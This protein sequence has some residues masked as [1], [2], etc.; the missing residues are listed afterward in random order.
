MNAGLS[1][2]WLLVGTGVAGGGIEGGGGAEGSAPNPVEGARKIGSGGVGG[3]AR[4]EEEDSRR[5]TK[6]LHG[7]SHQRVGLNRKP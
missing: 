2:A 5:G 3:G 1:V 7:S 4:T 6:A